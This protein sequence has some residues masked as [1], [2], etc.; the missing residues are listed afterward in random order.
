MVTSASAVATSSG[1]S[2][3][4]S[5]NVS[6]LPFFLQVGFFLM[7][8][9]E[10]SSCSEALADK[11]VGNSNHLPICQPKL[12]NKKKLQRQPLKRNRLGERKVKSLRS[13][14]QLRTH[15][16]LLQQPKHSSP[17]G[18]QRELMQTFTCILFQN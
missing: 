10:V 5:V 1:E 12:L 9:V 4:A 14:L 13:R 2:A 6:S 18:K 15:R 17:C 7:V 3:V 11:S 8:D 16:S